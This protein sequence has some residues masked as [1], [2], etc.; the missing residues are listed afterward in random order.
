[1]PNG[2][3][4]GP[5]TG[6]APEP[7]RTGGSGGGPAGEISRKPP[8]VPNRS[9]GS[10]YF[11]PRIRPRCRH[12]SAQSE[13]PTSRMPMALPGSDPITDLDPS[14]HRLIG[15][16]FGPVLDG[17][18]R[19]SRHH[20]G[21]GDGAARH[22][23]DE[24]SLLRREVQAAVAGAIGAGVAVESTLRVQCSRGDG[25]CIRG[26]NCR[27]RRHH[28]E[29]PQSSGTGQEHPGHTHG[30]KS[31]HEIHPSSDQRPRPAPGEAMCTDKHATWV[32]ISSGAPPC[33]RLTPSPLLG[34]IRALFSRCEVLTE[35]EVGS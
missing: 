9:P 25:P 22:G 10:R 27:L 2:D 35:H 24:I 19:T 6:R 14:G 30:G 13:C 5:A 16:T 15:G 20:P 21:P 23:V 7:A 1:M 32:W 33:S 11:S 31:S 34:E 26:R 4:T 17:D 12:A 3:V 28:A 8:S 18:G 29:A